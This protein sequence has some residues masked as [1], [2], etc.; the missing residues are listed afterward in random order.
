MTST[1]RNVTLDDK[2]VLERG[3]VYLTGIQ[4]LVRLPLD[5]IRR[6]RAA[7]LRTGGFVSGYRGSPLAGYDQQLARAKRLLGAHDL[8]FQPGVN[9]ELAATAVWGTQ[10]IGLAGTSDYDGVFGIWYGKAPGVDRAGDVLRHANASGTAALGGALAIAG[11]DHLAKSSSL[12]AQSEFAFMH[13]EIPVLNP[14]DLQDVLD[15]GL[16]GIAMSRY[17][18]LWTALIA[19]ADTMDSSGVISV[20]PNRLTIRRPMDVA[21]P[22]RGAD[23]NLSLR[24][25]NRLD[26]EVLTR[27]LRLP[28]A[29]A[30]ARANRLD[31]QVF[32]AERPRFGIVATGKA[33]RDLRQTLDLMGIDEVVA[34]EIGL[35]VF[36]VAMPWPLE[37]EAIGAFAG[38]LE[39]LLV[40][41][42]KRGV[43][44][45]QLKE[46]MFHWQADR[47]PLVFGKHAPDGRRLLPEIRECGPAEIAP[48]LLAFLPSGVHRPSMKEGAERLAARA[49]WAEENGT[50]AKRAP[51][52]CSGC[53]H[54][55]STLTPDGSRSMPGIGC[56]VMTEAAGRTTDGVVAMGGEGVPWLGQFPFSKDRH[57]FANL[58]DGTYY[59]SG[60]L[61]IR[62][63]VAAKAPIT[64]KILYNDAVAM[65]GGQPH[66][67]PLDVPQLVAQVAAEGVERIVLLSERPHLYSG[68]SL[69]PGVRVLERD[70][71]MT[72]QHELAAFP[73]VSV[74][75]Y[76]QTCAAEK[77]RRR[78]SGAYENPDIRLFIN[79]RVCEGCGDCSVQSN[80]VSVEP[81]PTLFGEK[82]RINQSS[83]NKDFSCQKGFC[84]SFVTV[85]GAEPRRADAAGFDIDGLAGEL[86]EP[87]IHLPDHP[88]NLLV[89]GIGGMGVT[90]TSAVLATAAFIDGLD[91]T[92]L[93]MTGLAQKNGPVTSHVRISRRDV[94]IEGP[95]VPVGA[96]DALIAADMLVAAGAEVLAMCAPDRTR[97]V[98]N[99]RVAPTAEFVLHQTQSF[100]AR[101]LRRAVSGAV[102]GIEGA[103]F[104][105]LAEAVMGDA[106]F[107]NMMLVGFAWQKGLVPVGRPAIERAIRLN[108]AAVSANLRAF[109]AGRLLA[110]RP[111]L[112]ER[113]S[114]QEA[115]P[116]DM[117]LDERIAF[118]AG[119]LTAYQDRA[120][121]ERFLASI[122]RLRAAEARATGD[123][124][125][126]TRTAAESLYRLMAYKDEYEVARLY[127]S[128]DFRQALEAQFDA[129]GKVSVQLA[130]PLLSRT[131]PN[132]GRPRKMTFG[133]W[134]FRAFGLLAAMKRLRGTWADPFG[135]T[136]E[137]REERALVTEFEALMDRL[138]HGLDA[139]SL[140][141]AIE[142]ARVPDTIRGYGPV[143]A[144]SIEKA[145]RRWADLVRR[146]DG[147]TA[148]PAP[149]LEAAE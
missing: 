33:Y 85:E 41:E 107:A 36:K 135:H 58:G 142:I 127:T 56:H 47:R 83:C 84:P 89:T 24:L 129:G 134:V 144:A 102:N 75:V 92:T 96:L 126:L 21:D 141:L 71:V 53:P 31:R 15:Y 78:K 2:Y 93:D 74:M 32:G 91:A 76:A 34:R 80:C 94:P 77:R 137:R 62:A 23:L 101:R 7:G 88:V 37:P 123:A 143:K 147:D 19:L 90:T 55:S 49:R 69:P 118:L 35:A 11:D 73:G 79:P 12:P 10:K 29:L 125:R 26:T 95:R 70:D 39:R 38:G 104:A 14:S 72:V 4:A 25:A 139:A 113:F 46:L 149:L 138:A 81:L 28:A 82:R 87:D 8:V 97:A 112:F 57:V 48:A 50:D 121:A 61:A 98:V 52:F 120:Y 27:D 131:D 124:G 146:W 3:Q 22:R 64:Y 109:A 148:Q 103:D 133:P 110:E 63:A 99:E 30:F 119:E 6:D 106:I 128:Q 114:A 43:I 45:P 68:L 108:G 60:I 44:E 66:D 116:Q 20:D 136:A 100:E 132:T 9:E 111:E 51:Y 117:S 105:R 17:S 67:G 1:A 145:R 86:A 115:S 54:N 122:G 18:G 130:P 13:A 40:V 140:G 42:H 65:T 5:Q 16:Y 59:H